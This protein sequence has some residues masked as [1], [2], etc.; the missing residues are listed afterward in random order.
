[1]PLGLALMQS[2]L[3]DFKAVIAALSLAAWRIHAGYRVT[4]IRRSNLQI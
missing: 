4:A 3:K 1:M 2:N